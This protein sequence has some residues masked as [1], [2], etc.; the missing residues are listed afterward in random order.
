MSSLE[1]ALIR[2][3]RFLKSKKIPY[4]IIGGVA[5]LFWGIPRTT[6]DIDVTIQVKESVQALIRQL[7]DKYHFRVKEPLSFVSK[8]NVL[9]VEDANGIRIDIICAKLPYEFQAIRRSRQVSVHGE[10]VRICS[11]EDLIVHK[12]ISDRP[13]DRD[14]VRGIIQHFGSKLNRAYLNPIV[15]DLAKALDKPE[16]LEFYHNCFL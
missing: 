3:A 15:R 14:D 9:P 7:K 16:I 1:Q 12:I 5:N 13:R 8:T 6:L 10:K 4:M 2:L 11:P